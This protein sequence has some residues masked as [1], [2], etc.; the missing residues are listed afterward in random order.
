LGLELDAQAK[1]DKET[2]R[3]QNYV[4]NINPKTPVMMTRNVMIKLIEQLHPTCY[5]LFTFT[6][7]ACSECSSSMKLNRQTKMYTCG[8]CGAEVKK[9]TNEYSV[10]TKTT[11]PRPTTK[12]KGAPQSDSQKIAGKIKFC[13]VVLANTK[14]AREELLSEITPDFIDEIPLKVKLIE[15]V[16]SY[17]ITNLIFPPRELMKN[18]KL[19][20]Y[21]TIRE[22]SLERILSVDSNSF[23]NV[24]QF[25]I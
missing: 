15:L 10:K 17:H 19:F 22:G 18:S 1:K 16:N 7:Y 4:C 3:V 5:L 20:R 6:I 9:P 23:E 21:R 24:I 2:K 12:Q 14:A 13:S 8:S 11:P 25:K